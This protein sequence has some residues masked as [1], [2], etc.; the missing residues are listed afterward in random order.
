MNT[1]LQNIAWS[2]LPKEFKEE[3]K[4]YF[5]HY[6]CALNTHEA[7]INHIF[8]RHNLTSDA[9][10]ETELLTVTRQ[11]V[12]GLYAN[13]KKI[14]NLY[15]SAT[16]INAN[17]SQQIDICIGIMSVLDT[18]F[19]SK[20]LPDEVV[21]AG[22]ATTSESKPAEPEEKSRNLS[23]ETANCDKHFDNILKDS[24]RNHNR[25][26]IAA[27][28][29]HGALSN[30]NIIRSC[31]DFESNDEYIVRTALLYADTLI[32]ECEKGGTDES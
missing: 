26:H 25:L 4:K 31:S 16:C 18:L 2:I 6:R 20:C 23:Q 11:K 1:E 22:N 3:V 21:V 9:E 29:V 15:T 14:H 32:A 12:M 5:A 24:F 8:G 28:M 19:G 7:I 27:I 17:E 30:P 10:G 13:A